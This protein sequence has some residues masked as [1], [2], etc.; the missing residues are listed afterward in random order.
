MSQLSA[1]GK[2]LPGQSLVRVRITVELLPDDK[3]TTQIKTDQY[4]PG[5]CIITIILI[6]SWPGKQGLTKKIVEGEGY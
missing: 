1:S 4:Q 6:L 3:I 2:L 5:Y